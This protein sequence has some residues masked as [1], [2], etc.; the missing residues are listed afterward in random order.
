MNGL[1]PDAHALVH[2]KDPLGPELLFDAFCPFKLLKPQD[3]WSADASSRLDARTPYS[4]Q[5]LTTHEDLFERLVA[6]CLPMKGNTRRGEGQSLTNSWLCKN[7]HRLKGPTWGESVLDEWLVTRGHAQSR[8]TRRGEGQ[9]L[10]NS[11]VREDT[12][13]L[14]AHDAGRVSP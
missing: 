9:S 14:E 1:S 4:T 5:N 11:W 12:H 13:E 6:V 3:S 2:Q 8:S 7:T 10:M